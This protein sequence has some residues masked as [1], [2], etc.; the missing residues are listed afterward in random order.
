M[1]CVLPYNNVAVAG[2]MENNPGIL[3]IHVGSSAQWQPQRHHRAA[4]DP[5]QRWGGCVG[6]SGKVSAHAHGLPLCC[7]CLE[8]EPLCRTMLWEAYFKS[9]H[10]SQHFKSAT[11]CCPD[12]VIVVFLALAQAVT[13]SAQTMLNTG[14]TL[15]AILNWGGSV[16]WGSHF[17]CYIVKRLE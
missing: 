14:A 7:L 4:T 12:W 13:D 16:F 1:N 2:G 10:K 8:L 15:P 5:V 11:F 3:H 6:H 17:L 9:H